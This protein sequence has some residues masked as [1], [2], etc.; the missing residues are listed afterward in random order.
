MRCMILCALAIWC[1]HAPAFGQAE[2]DRLKVFGYFQ[3]ALGSQ[4]DLQTQREENSFTLQ[5]LNLFLQ[6]NL[7]QNWTAFINLEFVNNYSS[8][9]G[10]GAFSL[11]EAWINYRRSNQFKLKLGLL[12]PEFNNL[13]AIKN[14]TPLLPY[15]IR[16]V[17]YESSFREI[18][19]TED[20]APARAF[21]QA[22]GFI[23]AGQTKFEYAGY[24]GNSPSINADPSRG[25]TGLDTSRTFLAGSRVGLRHKFLK[26]G[27]STAF[28]KKNFS[29]YADTL[30]VPPSA[31][32]SLLRVRLGG[33]LSFQDEH[34]LF[35]GE[36]IH[37]QHEASH[38]GIEY[39]QTFY[40]G[41]AGY[42][43]SERFLAYASYWKAR[44]E[45]QP[46]ADETLEIPT[47]GVTYT[48][49]DM[50]ILKAQT[51]RVHIESAELPNDENYDYSYFAVSV[52]F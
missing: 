7:T 4:K 38:A 43:F 23:P 25:I 47:L 39:R 42:Y 50:I 26:A 34:W 30:N 9:F 41:T 14:R 8:L 37:V 6:K 51:G 28:D 2:D 16:P 35:E 19:A 29:A 52:V 33:D 40:Y 22:Y 13:N 20:Y 45:I 18:V 49:N 46:I 44:A 10:W 17:V 21:V 15:I 48:L 5:Q 32:Q 36:I 31:L 3:A 24:L 1:W 11:E 12:T 27:F